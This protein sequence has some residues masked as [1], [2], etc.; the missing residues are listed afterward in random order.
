[1]WGGLTVNVRLQNS[2]SEFYREVVSELP[3][4]IILFSF[5]GNIED[6]EGGAELL[7]ANPS[8]YAT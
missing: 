7:A 8:T 2:N 1:M 3:R 6:D 4:W 5:S